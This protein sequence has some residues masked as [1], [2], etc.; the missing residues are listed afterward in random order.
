M[1]VFSQL[2]CKK[3]RAKIQNK[4]TFILFKFRE[5]HIKKYHR[6]SRGG[7]TINYYFITS[8]TLLLILT[9]GATNKYKIL[10]VLLFLID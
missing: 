6:F 2:I 1:Q 7:G 9:K 4:S 8:K 10:F 3:N 5:Q